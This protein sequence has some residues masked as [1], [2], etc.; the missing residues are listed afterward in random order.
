MTELYVRVT[1]KCCGYTLCADICPEV[2]SLDESGFAVAGAEAVREDLE[3]LVHEAVESCPEAAIEVHRGPFDA[4]GGVQAPCCERNLDTVDRATR[5]SIPG[6]PL[7]RSNDRRSLC[8][9]N[10]AVASGT[11]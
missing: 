2:F 1:T 4:G 3:A 5:R 8:A 11:P 10:T 9:S 7:P 6:A